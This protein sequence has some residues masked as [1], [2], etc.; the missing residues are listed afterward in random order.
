MKT[1]STILRLI[2][3]SSLFL[4]SKTAL[5]QDRPMGTD[6]SSY[7]S[8]IDWQVVKSDG[9]FFAW[10]K[11]TEGPPGY[12]YDSF[13][14]ENETNA[15]T[16]GVLIGAYHYAHPSLDTN[17]TGANSADTEAQYFWSKAS[18][19]VTAGGG[20]LV[21]MLDWEDPA[22]KSPNQTVASMSAWANEW[23]NDISNYARAN[24]VVIRPVIYTGE[25]YGAEWLNSTVT[26]W[27]S[28]IAA[29]PDGTSGHYGS[30]TP[31]T[32]SPGGYSP[33]P[34]WNIWQYG[35]TNWS[36]GD[37]DVFNGTTNQF[38]QLFLVGSTNAPHIATNPPSMTVAEGSNVTLSVSVSGGTPLYYHWQF[39]GTNVSTVTN[40][41]TNSVTYAIPDAQLTN[42]GDYE[43]Q[44]SNAYGTVLTTP[45]F[46]SVTAPLSNAPGSVIAPAGMVDWWPANGNAVD[47]VS[48][49][50]GAPANG[51]YYSS[52]N[53]GRAF[54]F[55]G[56][57]SYL[58]MTNSPTS[59]AV[60]W[61]ACMWVYRQQTPQTSAAL[62]SDG[63]NTL[64]LEQYNDT[65]DVG[66]TQLSV[67]DWPFSPAYSVPLNTWTHLAFVASGSTTTLYVNGVEEG[68]ISAAIPLGRKTMGVTYVTGTGYVDYMEGS[69]DQVMLFNKALSAAQ[70]QSI[71]NSGA[72][73]LVQAPQFLGVSSDGNGNFIYSVEGLTGSRNIIIDY[74]TNLPYWLPLT[75]LSAATGS[76]QFTVTPTNAA[77]FY[78][79]VQP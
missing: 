72:A 37:S 52:G 78:R 67:Q 71:Y 19:Y 45:A 34:T 69:M 73:S 33:W 75:S 57:T 64:K 70:I 35:D 54:H 13:F 25:D 8:N 59:I 39:D 20:Y 68:T 32:S 48:G 24:G 76:T 41:N 4:I 10:A 43:V 6:V 23:C 42:A 3:L 55:D 61:T 49:Y 60:P 15:K 51:F 29:Y 62:I 9:I 7:Q 65:H 27:P 77:T 38:L 30:P 40:F 17:I 56:A 2:F 28:W 22:V 31:Q 79:A 11:A 66:M 26:N 63:T 12:F 46:L 44:I 74:S 53:S 16:A 21:P 36:G 58:T 5:A 50:N 1:I 14:V 47:I 18:N